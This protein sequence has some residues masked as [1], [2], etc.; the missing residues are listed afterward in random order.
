[1][2]MVIAFLDGLIDAPAL[3]MPRRFCELVKQP[4]SANAFCIAKLVVMMFEQQCI[5]SLQYL[6]SM[7]AGTHVVGTNQCCHC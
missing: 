2:T 7:T 6:T 4:A 1:M 5:G 3:L